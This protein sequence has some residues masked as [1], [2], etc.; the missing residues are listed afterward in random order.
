MKTR[1]EDFSEIISD[2]LGSF[3]LSKKSL[4]KSQRFFRL[5]TTQAKYPLSQL[6]SDSKLNED[7]MDTKELS[8][9]LVERA[10]NEDKNMNLDSAQEKVL[11]ILEHYTEGIKSAVDSLTSD[12][13]L[14]LFP[15][16]LASNFIEDL[17]DGALNEDEEFEAKFEE[18]LNYLGRKRNSRDIEENLKKVDNF[19]KSMKECLELS[20]KTINKIKNVNAFPPPSECSIKK[21]IDNAWT[22]K[23]PSLSI[24]IDFL[25][26]NSG[27]ILSN[28]N[29]GFHI[30]DVDNDGK[31]LDG[32]FKGPTKLYESIGVRVSPLGNLAAVSNSKGNSIS[33]IDLKNCVKMD[34]LDIELKKQNRGEV[35]A[36]D[37]IDNEWIL[38][39]CDFGV[40]F[41]KKIDRKS[42]ENLLNFD[43]I[44]PRTEKISFL[45]RVENNLV[46]MGTVDGN[47]FVLEVAKNSIKM[48]WKEKI[49]NMSIVHMELSPE[50]TKVV[51]SSK[52]RQLTVFDLVNLKIL[53]QGSISDIPV[54]AGWGP[55]A[56][57]IIAFGMI[58]RKAFVLKEDGLLV[59]EFNLPFSASSILMTQSQNGACEAIIG[60]ANGAIL[61]LAFK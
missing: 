34:D 14:E 43:Y 42:E 20:I 12:V 32:N 33:L 5:Q 3:Q 47:F 56:S 40:L 57:Y 60:G 49:S 38:F 61:R 28:P 55:A 2:R 58:T 50:K 8:K 41:S 51:C 24:G 22:G 44:I 46:L 37:W 29:G 25:K 11:G 18:L 27:Y 52:N 35:T 39:G 23:S 19:E 54:G 30:A 31:L 1:Y 17:A 53:G 4:N 9:L 45:K 59:R 6:V 13:M 10:Q 15:R 48:R 36:F 7:Y 21:R 16:S 26:G